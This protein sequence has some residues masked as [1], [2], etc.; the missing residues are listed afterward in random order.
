MRDGIEFFAMKQQVHRG[1]VAEIDPM[2]RHFPS[3]SRDI[4]ALDLRIVKIVEII[5]DRDFLTSRE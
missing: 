1:A 2:D 3:D 4:G 5:E